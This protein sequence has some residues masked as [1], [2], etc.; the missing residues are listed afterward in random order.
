MAVDKGEIKIGK[1]KGTKNLITA[2]TIPECRAL[3]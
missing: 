2:K 3:K 1:W